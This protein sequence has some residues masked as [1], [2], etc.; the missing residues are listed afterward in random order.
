M[1]DKILNWI[2]GVYGPII[3]LLFIF[4]ILIALQKI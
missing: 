4:G 1:K 2:L 3:L